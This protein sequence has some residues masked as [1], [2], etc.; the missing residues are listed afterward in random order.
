MHETEIVKELSPL[1]DPRSIAVI[2]ATNDVNKW[3]FLTFLSIVSE[4]KGKVYPV[5]WKEEKVLGYPAFKKVTDIPDPVDLAVFVIPGPN[6]PAVMEE[7]VEKGVRSAVIISAGFAEMGGEGKRLEEDLIRV[8]KKGKIPFVGPNC[9]G[10][11]SASSNLSALMWPTPFRDGPFALVSQGGNLGVAMAMDAYKRG[12]GFHRY[13]SCGRSVGIQIE[14]YIEYFGKDPEVKVILAYIEGLEDGR[15]F[16][17]KVKEVSQKKPVV[18]LKPGKSE[19]TERAIRSHSG[20]LSGSYQTYGEAFKKAGALRVDNA[21][22][23]LDV[24]TGLLSQPLPK[25][26]NV[27]IVTPGGSYGVMC[28]DCCTPLNLN[29]VDLPKDVIIELNKMF[30]PRWS[31]EN[32]IDPAGDRNFVAYIKAVERVLELK[33]VDSLIF[34]GFGG[35]SGII[36]FNSSIVKGMT[37]FMP[38]IV[39]AVLSEV[40]L[41]RL[42]IQQFLHVGGTVVK[43]LIKKLI[44]RMVGGGKNIKEEPVTGLMDFIFEKSD[45][46]GMISPFLSIIAPFISAGDKKSAEDFSPLILPKIESN[47]ADMISIAEDVISNIPSAIRSFFISWQIDPSTIFQVI[48]SVLGVIVFHWIKTYKKPI[49]TTTFSEATT[50]LMTLERGFYF[51][52]P[53]PERATKVLA[54]LV[55]YNEYLD[56]ECVPN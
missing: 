30:P 43:N 46:A 21:E 8:A 52:Y 3:G 29:V 54:K 56:K 51:A 31:H 19:V 32:P 14:D 49:I 4:F 10:M 33:E 13:V 20:A 48:D 12:I 38:E 18:V 23:L 35:F 41:G 24:A 47:K 22:E 40:D 53:S 44:D 9:M 55:E 1:F 42:D 28:A 37:R 15:R 5:N 36:E 25:G 26:R 17:D 7:C 16:I 50:R 11:W 45:I 34:M 27:A 39:T 2:G 6:V